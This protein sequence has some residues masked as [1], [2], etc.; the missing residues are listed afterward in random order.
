MES[1]VDLNRIV[2]AAAGDNAF[3]WCSATSGNV[4][5]TTGALS[6]QVLDAIVGVYKVYTG[7]G[8]QTSDVSWW[9]KAH[10][11]AASGLNCGHWT[12]QCEE[13]FRRRCDGILAGTMR[14]RK[15][16]DWQSGMRLQA[17]A[18]KSVLRAMDDEYPASDS[19]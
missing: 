7:K 14:P 19:T 1:N 13:W 18:T 3:A 15:P 8:M 17:S 9:P 6:A 12:F 4:V 11:W 16:K 2:A 5:L 10:T